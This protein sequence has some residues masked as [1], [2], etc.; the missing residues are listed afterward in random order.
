MSG[1]VDSDDRRLAPK[2][3]R[4][5]PREAQAFL[6]LKN[7]AERDDGCLPRKYRELMS[8]AVAVAVAAQCGYCID[9]HVAKARAAGASAEELAE[10]VFIAA[11]L[12]AG[13]AAAH[14]LLALRLFESSAATPA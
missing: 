2:L 1:Y 14:G 10:T 4:L 8:V 3:A 11:A 7:A 6:A 12:R 9:D 5:A 13:A